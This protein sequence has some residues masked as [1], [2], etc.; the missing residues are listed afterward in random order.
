MGEGGP[1]K[2]MSITGSHLLK[3]KGF[4]PHT[5]HENKFQMDQKFQ[6]KKNETIN[7]LKETTEKCFYSLTESKAFLNM[8]ENIKAIKEKI[9]IFH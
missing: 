1:F 8:T 6:C 4:L 9:D 3:I 2:S 7:I 5:L